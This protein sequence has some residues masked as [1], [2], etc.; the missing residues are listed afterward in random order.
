MIQTIIALGD[1]HDK[2]TYFDFSKDGNRVVTVSGNDKIKFFLKKENKF[3]LEKTFE[4]PGRS[5]TKVL[6]DERNNQILGFDGETY[7]NFDLHTMK[8]KAE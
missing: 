7:V 6:L 2:I 1:E 5:F 3:E 8:K 4:S